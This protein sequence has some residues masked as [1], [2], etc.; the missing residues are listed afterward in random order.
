MEI[1]NANVMQNIT[2]L[3]IQHPALQLLAHNAIPVIQLVILVLV[4]L[5]LNVHRAI[6]LDICL[7]ENVYHALIIAQ[8]VQLLPIVNHAILTMY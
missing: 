6:Q 8:H 7:Q 3:L 4:Q 2:W 1:M 5:L